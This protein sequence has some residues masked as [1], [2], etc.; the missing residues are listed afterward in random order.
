MPPSWSYF[1]GSGS[2][3]LHLAGQQPAAEAL[4]GKGSDGQRIERKVGKRTDADDGGNCRHAS[5]RRALALT[6]RTRGRVL[7]PPTWPEQAC[8]A[9]RR[10]EDPGENSPALH[11]TNPR[12]QPAKGSAL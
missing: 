2:T 11:A 6:S 8:F 9:C 1:G 7:D 3:A 5:A 4:G 10:G 12:G